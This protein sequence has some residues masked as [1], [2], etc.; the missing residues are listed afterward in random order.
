MRDITKGDVYYADLDPGLLSEQRGIRPV[1]IL[2][3]YWSEKNSTDVIVAPLT[4]KKK[5]WLPTH[6]KLAKTDFMFLDKDSTLLIEQVRTID[7]R[8]LKEY[9]GSLDNF[10]L[11]LIENALSINFGMFR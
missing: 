1:V 8:S 11:L 6:V 2:Q 3:N 4:S 7:K 10:R 9:K 5:K